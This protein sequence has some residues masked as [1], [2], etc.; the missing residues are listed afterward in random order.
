MVLSLLLF[1]IKLFRDL[2]NS[3]LEYIQGQRSKKRKKER[4]KEKKKGKHTKKV[5]TKTS[6]QS[7]FI[8]LILMTL[9]SSLKSALLRFIICGQVP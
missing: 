6:Q 8:L 3:Y 2:E 4:K 5:V 7:Y 1:K 9:S